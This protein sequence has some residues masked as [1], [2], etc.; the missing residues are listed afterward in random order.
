[1][2]GR[3]SSKALPFTGHTGGNV[4]R[5]PIRTLRLASALKS[6]PLTNGGSE[7]GEDKGREAE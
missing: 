6:H 5:K 4:G 1:M 7:Q 3:V 2:N